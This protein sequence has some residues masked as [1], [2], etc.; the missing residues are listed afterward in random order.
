MEA[1]AQPWKQGGAWRPERQNPLLSKQKLCTQGVLL[2]QRWDTNVIH[3]SAYL[4]ARVFIVCSP[5]QLHQSCS[6][7]TFRVRGLT[8][9]SA[10]SPQATHGMKDWC[11]D[12]LKTV[13]ETKKK[14][15]IRLFTWRSVDQEPP[16]TARGG[17]LLILWFHRSSAPLRVSQS[18]N[19]QTSRQQSS[20][21][22]ASRLYSHSRNSLWMVSNEKKHLWWKLVFKKRQDFVLPATRGR[23]NKPS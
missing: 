2:T 1:E 5:H 12:C 20:D 21:E 15:F 17:R 7:R 19:S 16:S 4:K 22:Q 13:E 3:W 8:A 9:G 14:E 10:L 11:S 18:S 6:P 23:S